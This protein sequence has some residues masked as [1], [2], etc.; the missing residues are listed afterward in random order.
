MSHTAFLI[1]WPLLLL[2]G[3]AQTL[4][5]T[6]FLVQNL[7]K[8]AQ[9]K[10]YAVSTVEIKNKEDETEV[11]GA[12]FFIGKDGLF[13]TSYHVLKKFLN[14]NELLLWIHPY[15]FERTLTKAKILA[16]EDE[17]KIDLCLLKF[18]DF[19]PKS[20]FHSAPI[21]FA[22]GHEGVFIG[23]CDEDFYRVVNGNIKAVY[24]D[25]YH[26]ITATKLLGEYK[27]DYNHKVEM[28][29]LDT[30]HC[31]GD[32]GG[33]LFGS[34]GELWGVTQEWISIGPKPEYFYLFISANEVHQYVEKN[35][36]N[37]GR[38]IPTDRMIPFEFSVMK[39]LNKTK[40]NKSDKKRQ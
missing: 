38:P 18:E 4:A 15:E 16:C 1:L 23:H 37:P 27:P 2:W 14:D 21:K 9:E 32:S 7:D 24:P 31:G 26:F 29:Q 6:T 28:V 39:K 40:P 33:P 10:K 25:I 19:K 17:R 5:Q 30:R 11:R 36:N 35:Q 22:L 12:G 8:L 13:V 3:S 20:Y 34:Q